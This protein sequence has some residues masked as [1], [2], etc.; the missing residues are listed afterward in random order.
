[1]SE[2]SESCFEHLKQTGSQIC[3]DDYPGRFNFDFFINLTEVSSKRHYM[4]SIGT[5]PQLG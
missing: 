4:V 5:N 3:I 2:D 1:M